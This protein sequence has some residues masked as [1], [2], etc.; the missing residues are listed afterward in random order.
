M[1]EP[2]YLGWSNEITM[3]FWEL[4]VTHKSCRTSWEQMYDAE[5]Q[6]QRSLLISIGTR[7]WAQ[8]HGIADADAEVA[9]RDV[10]WPM[11][12]REIFDVGKFG[13]F[14]KD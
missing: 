4:L 14:G 2:D 13:M 8:R 11:V 7:L 12:A 1:C 10:S 3:K 9:L 6:K 5:E